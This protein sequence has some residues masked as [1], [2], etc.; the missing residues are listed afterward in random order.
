[1]SFLRAFQELHHFRSEARANSGSMTVTISF[2]DENDLARFMMQLQR[3]IE[4][5]M[6]VIAGDVPDATKLRKLF[7]I[8]V[9]VAKK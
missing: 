4:P 7:G 3:D 1:M 8:N 6:R 2:D 9:S 5:H